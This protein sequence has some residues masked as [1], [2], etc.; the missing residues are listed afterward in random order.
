MSA[1]V[2]GTF[3]LWLN[4]VRGF[5]ML[6]V[7]R[8]WLN[9]RNMNSFWML[10]ELPIPKPRRSDCDHCAQLGRSVGFTAL[11]LYDQRSPA[12]RLRGGSWRPVGNYYLIVQNP[13]DF[14]PRGG[15]KV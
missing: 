15:A 6:D 3:R 8:L 10:L 11:L 9:G 14:C 7:P 12:Y 5:W 13:E 1:T 2:A 4:G